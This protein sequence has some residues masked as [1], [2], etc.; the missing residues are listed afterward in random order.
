[1]QQSSS[2]WDHKTSCSFVSAA[3]DF[4]NF[5][6]EFFLSTNTNILQVNLFYSFQLG[7]AENNFCLENDLEIVF[8][9]GV[10]WQMAVRRF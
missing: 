6:F 3:L 1:M 2:G 7:S 4:F 8:F 5:T 10:I 9:I